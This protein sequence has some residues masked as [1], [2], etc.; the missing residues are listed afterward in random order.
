MNTVSQ[1]LVA[2]LFLK[3]YGFNISFDRTQFVSSQSEARSTVLISYD[4]K[5]LDMPRYHGHFK[6]KKC[7]RT[8]NEK[9]FYQYNKTS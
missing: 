1:S 8:K 9:S 6:V 7:Y 5:S 4:I 2:V 3:R